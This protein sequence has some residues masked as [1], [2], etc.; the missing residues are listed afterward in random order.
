MDVSHTFLSKV[1]KSKIRCGIPGKD[2][3]FVFDNHFF[4]AYCFSNLVTGFLQTPAI[5]FSLFKILGGQQ[6]ENALPACGA[7]QPT[8]IKLFFCVGQPAVR[9]IGPVTVRIVNGM[10]PVRIVNGIDPELRTF[11]TAATAS[12]SNPATDLGRA[13]ARHCCMMSSTGTDVEVGTPQ[14]NVL[15]EHPLCRLFCLD[16]DYRNFE[17]VCEDRLRDTLLQAATTL[18]PQRTGF[19]CATFST[20]SFMS[21]VSL[22]GAPSV[23]S[24]SD[25]IKL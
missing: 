10:G 19:C 5:S 18:V 1:S 25:E 2:V 22:M 9:G 21:R 14:R 17:K 24:P 16:L 12:D 8:T 4:I 13:N 23:V 20:W 7:P 15:L 3:F 6:I 11:R